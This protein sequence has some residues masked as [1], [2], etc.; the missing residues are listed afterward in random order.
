MSGSQSIQVRTLSCGARLA[1]EEM[2]SV[3][4]CGMT[5]ILPMGSASDPS[6]SAGEGASTLLSEL[7]ARG[8]GSMDSKALSDAFDAI[9]ASRVSASGI[10]HT[11]LGSQSLGTQVDHALELLVEMIRRPTIADHELDPVRSLALQSIESLPDSPPSMAALELMRIAYPAPFNRSGMGHPEGLLLWDTNALRERW[12]TMALPVGAFIGVAGAVNA[13][14]IEATLE[15]LL[16]GWTGVAKEPV[17]SHPAIGGIAHIAKE[18][19]QTHI[20]MA[21]S[22]PTEDHP[23]AMAFRVLVRILGGGSS[24]R[25]FTE[26]RERRGLCYSVGMGA[27]LGR[28]RGLA[29]VMAGSTPERASE[30][31]EQ[32]L[33]Q[34]E[35]ARH[36]VTEEEFSIART[37]LKSGLVMS[38]E[39][40]RARSSAIVGDLYRTG[41]PR[42]LA[43]LAAQVDALTLDSVNEV[44]SRLMSERW[45][46]SR[47][48]AF[49]G[50]RIPEGVA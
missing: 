42:T 37:G 21:L 50:P 27:S 30:T 3:R 44:A 14:A 49:V 28:D 48:S 10:H 46:Q 13:D 4:S 39:S 7:I 16:S 23:D 15:R 25:L 17:E 19:A 34:L 6:G 2:S 22:A 35:K 1:V 24:S 20:A 36:G 43:S 26:V 18:T 29:Q 33:V 41:T 31:C 40:S 9:G 12:R 38:G 5:I 11:I 32:I 45:L 8:A 47:S